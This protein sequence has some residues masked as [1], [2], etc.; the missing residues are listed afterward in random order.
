MKIMNSPV[1]YCTFLESNWTLSASYVLVWT[2]NIWKQNGLEKA[3]FSIPKNKIIRQSEL[4]R[5]QEHAFYEVESF[6]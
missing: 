5:I 4:I 3:L 1:H 6:E 2:L